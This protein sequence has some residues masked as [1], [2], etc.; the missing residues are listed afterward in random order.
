M[1][2]LAGAFAF[3][4]LREFLE[5]GPTFYRRYTLRA[6]FSSSLIVLALIVFQILKRSRITYVLG[7]LYLLLLSYGVLISS[8]ASF[9]R[10]M[11][12]WYRQPDRTEIVADFVV[13]I[14]F[15]ALLVKLCYHFI[16]GL[17]SRRF[18]RI[19]PQFR[20]SGK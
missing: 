15:T 5:H 6:A 4:L 10:L 14:L 2:I 16:F 20:P 12:D 8:Y 1:W 11:E 9:Q 13:A 3:M 18:Y 19:R 7:V 17:P